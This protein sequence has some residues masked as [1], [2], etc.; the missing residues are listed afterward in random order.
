MALFLKDAMRF[1][2]NLILLTFFFFF[3]LTFKAASNCSIVVQVSL[4]NKRERVGNKDL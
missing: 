1:V 3:N 2:L 4:K